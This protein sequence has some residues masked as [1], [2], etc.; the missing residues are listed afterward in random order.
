MV[1]NMHTALPEMFYAADYRHS[2]DQKN[3][4]SWNSDKQSSRIMNMQTRI[5]N[6]VVSENG[7]LQGGEG[8]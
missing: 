6:S 4:R 3:V 8:G 5:V 7:A 2:D 1:C